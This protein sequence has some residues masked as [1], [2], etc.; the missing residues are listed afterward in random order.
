MPKQEYVAP[1]A[2]AS[3]KDLLIEGEEMTLDLTED[4]WSF[5]APP[6]FGHSF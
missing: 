6:P 5:G 3:L 1:K 2:I 4:A